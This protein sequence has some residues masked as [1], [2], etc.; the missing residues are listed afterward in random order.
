MEYANHLSVGLSFLFLDLVFRFVCF[1]LPLLCV[2]VCHVSVGAKILEIA[3]KS[4]AQAI[5]PGYGKTRGRERE[6]SGKAAH[7]LWPHA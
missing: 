4:G 2:V 3:K 6:R 7:E 5:H 1:F